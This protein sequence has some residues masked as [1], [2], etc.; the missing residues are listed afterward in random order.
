MFSWD[1]PPIVISITLTLL[2]FPPHSLAL[3]PGF[4]K[5]SI[6]STTHTQHTSTSKTHVCCNGIEERISRDTA[7]ALM[8][9]RG[10][11]EWCAVSAFLHPVFRLNDPRPRPQTPNLSYAL[12]THA[13]KSNP[14]YSSLYF[15]LLTFVS[16]VSIVSKF[17]DIFLYYCMFFKWNTSINMTSL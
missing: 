10:T 13:T 2:L 5:H 6:M 4:Q 8:H 12:Y 1:Y 11:Q 7:T 9:F 14:L 16:C 17:H 15:Y 3:S